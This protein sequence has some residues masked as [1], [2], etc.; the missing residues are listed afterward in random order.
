LTEDLFSV[1]VEDLGN[2]LKYLE[3][4]LASELTE[5]YTTL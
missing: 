2:V 5:S 4:K 1:F 3:I